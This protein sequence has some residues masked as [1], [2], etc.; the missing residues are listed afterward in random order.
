[1]NEV[2]QLAAFEWAACQT[3]EG[4]RRVLTGLQPGHDRAGR[5]A[6][7]G[8]ERRPAVVPPDAHGRAARQPRAAQSGRPAD[9]AGRSLHH[10]LRDL[11]RAQ[12]P[13]R[14]RRRGR[15]RAAAT[16]PPTT[17]S[18]WSRPTSRR[19]P[20]GTARCTSAR[21]VASCSGSST[22]TSA[23]R[24]SA[25]TS[26]PATS[27]TSTSGSTRPCSPARRSSCAPAWRC[28]ATSSRPPARRTS[29]RT[30]R[31][32]SRWPT[33]RCG[34]SWRRPTRGRGSASRRGAGSWR[35]ALGIDLHA[36]VLPLS[37]LAGHLPPF[38]LRPDRAMTP[39]RV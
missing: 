13:G 28:S 37:N 30:S 31:T 4:V 5:G 39:R 21:S 34:R 36:D 3:S 29:R 16:A 20:S 32:A 9:R 27:C 17:S 38:L 25:S 8:V 14:L 19:S 18:D 24:S 11:G 26:T 33:S 7:A 35:D 6:P 2:D 22:A 15:R 10:R 23:T 12:L 1:M